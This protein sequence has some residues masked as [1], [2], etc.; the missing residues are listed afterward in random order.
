MTIK[1]SKQFVKHLLVTIAG[2]VLFTIF[3][4]YG[5]LVSLNQ[6]GRLKLA[7]LVGVFITT[8]AITATISIRWGILVNAL[9]EKRVAEWFEYYRYFIINRIL[10][11]ILPKDSTDLFGRAL[12]LYRHHSLSLM[13]SGA[14]VVFDRLFDLLTT[15][16]FLFSAIPYWIGIVD[17][18]EGLCIMGLVSALLFAAIW[19]LY[20]PL[21]HFF[22]WASFRSESLARYLP[23]FKKFS[24]NKD[25]L[26]LISK[27][28][29][30][31]TLLLSFFKFVFTSGRF[32][33]ITMALGLSINPNLI[34][35]ATPLGQL[36]YLI[37]I[38][39]GGLGIIEAGWFGILSIA[40]ID[41]EPT[42]LFVV[43]QRVLIVA[44]ISILVIINQLTILIIV[45]K[46]I[47]S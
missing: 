22:I 11:F 44:C 12:L 10:G 3:I 33:L 28:V 18:N 41:P 36:T 20:R 1:L 14:S 30:F 26:F 9:G 34:V 19:L 31:T 15:F 25:F 37:A 13:R 38:T 23:G 21:F 5:G 17:I 32:V 40:G 16:I 7:P 24:F 47:E 42:L 39:P 43:G 29:L 2:L 27:R 45:G 35:L 8:F 6:F 4:F 46:K